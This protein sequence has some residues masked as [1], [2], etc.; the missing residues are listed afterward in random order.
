MAIYTSA[1]GSVTL[2]SSN[3]F[4]TSGEGS[5]KISDGTNAE[6][7]TD[8]SKLDLPLPLTT[9]GTIEAIGEGSWFAG[10]SAAS[11]VATS[12][13]I[14]TAGVSIAEHTIQGGNGAAILSDGTSDVYVR[15]NQIAYP[16]SLSD[17]SKTVTMVPVGENSF[18]AHE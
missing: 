18:V 7:F 1:D 13:T 3:N 10:Q 9:S 14:A 6:I 8:I 5:I 4:L 16:F 17:S 2:S 15:L 12:S 11:A